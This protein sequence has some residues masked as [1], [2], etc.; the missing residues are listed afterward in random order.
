MTVAPPRWVYLHG[1][2]GGP[3][4][5]AIAGC[6]GSFHFVPDRRRDAPGLSFSAYCDDL[7]NRIAQ[8]SDGGPLRLVGFSLGARMALEMADRLGSQVELVALISAA[9]PLDHGNYLPDMAG[10][11][12]FRAAQLSRWLLRWICGGQAILARWAP[13]TLVDL[14]LA[15]A[16]AGDVRL[17]EDPGFR[18]TM[19]TMLTLSL[20]N[21]APGYR[22]EVEAYVEP[23]APLLARITAPVVIRHGTHDNWAPPAMAKA[24]AAAL[25]NVSDFTMLPGHSHYST[26]ARTLA[27]LCDQ[28]LS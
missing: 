4:E 27:D 17:A 14:L 3:E 1:F 13:T 6:M 10:R 28:R 23:W 2:P 19:Q 12:V 26:L 20:R 9:G 11:P 7:A 8:V 15:S 18:S 5:L 21:G 24:L 22:R 16:R 25:P